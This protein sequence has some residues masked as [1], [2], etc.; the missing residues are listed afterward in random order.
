MQEVID[1]NVVYHNV[2]IANDNCQ[3]FFIDMYI[4]KVESANFA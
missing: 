2:Q 1:V 3:I 4:Y